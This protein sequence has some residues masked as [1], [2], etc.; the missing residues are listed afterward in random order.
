LSFKRNGKEVGKTTAAPI[1]H[2]AVRPMASA[3]EK[4]LMKNRIP[5]G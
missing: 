5:F 4:R 1:K 2:S 3:A